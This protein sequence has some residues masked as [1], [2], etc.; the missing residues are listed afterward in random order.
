MAS[1]DADSLNLPPPP[2]TTLDATTLDREQLLEDVDD[3]MPAENQL[4]Y[5][6]LRTPD[7]RRADAANIDDN[8]V[9]DND[10][11]R[12]FIGQEEFDEGVQRWKEVR[13]Y[14]YHLK[15]RI[16]ERGR[17]KENPIYNNFQFLLIIVQLLLLLY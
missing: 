7:R 11:L 12:H 15:K 10:E 4:V 9:I 13:Y 3:E 16:K 6:T 2:T 5:A 1:N 8:D 17:E 14:H